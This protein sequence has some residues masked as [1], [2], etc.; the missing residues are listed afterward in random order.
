MFAEHEDD[1]RHDVCKCYVVFLDMLAEF[2]EVEFGH[3][4]EGEAGIEGLV[5]EAREALE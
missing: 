1:G 5:D 4:D 2:G 3:N